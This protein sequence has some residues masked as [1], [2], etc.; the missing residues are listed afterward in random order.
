MRYRLIWVLMAIIFI[1][2][3]HIAAFSRVQYSI[4]HE[5]SGI[6]KDDGKCYFVLL[7][8]PDFQNEN[9]KNDIKQAVR[10]IAGE[11]GGKITLYFFDDRKLLEE[12]YHAVIQQIPKSLGKK[13]VRHHIA[14]F[15]GQYQ[16]G[17]FY[18]YIYFFPGLTLTNFDPSIGKYIEWEIFDPAK[19]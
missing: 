16:V 7:T 5:A 14:T 3:A 13:E 17:S 10:V 4:I 2:S 11:K 18:N 6:R 15:S 8:P 12:Y 1:N 19:D 9:F